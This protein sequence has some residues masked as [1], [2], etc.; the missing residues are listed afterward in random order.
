MERQ[1]SVG[2]DRPDKEDYLWRWTTFPGKISTWTEAFHLC[3]DRNVR[4][5]WRNGNHP[6]KWWSVLQVC[7]QGQQGCETFNLLHDEKGKTSITLV[8][9]TCTGM[10]TLHIQIVLSRQCMY[11]TFVNCHN[12]TVDSNAKTGM[13]VYSYLILILY[14]FLS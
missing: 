9:Y 13:Q 1:V 7:C 3:F 14:F 8:V 12:L 4:K 10:N 11:L 6:T 2:P 5:F